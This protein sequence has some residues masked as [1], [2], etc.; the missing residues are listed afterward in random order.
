[1]MEGKVTH[2]RFPL[3]LRIIFTFYQWKHIGRLRPGGSS[4]GPWAAGL[5]GPWYDD[6]KSSRYAES[7]LGYNKEG[8]NPGR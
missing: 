8:P 7:L 4:V 5:S 3:S 2:D 1:M 6:G